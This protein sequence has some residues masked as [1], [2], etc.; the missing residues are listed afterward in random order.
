MLDNAKDH[1]IEIHIS[2]ISCDD[3]QTIKGSDISVSSN[4]LEYCL[5]E[6]PLLSREK[7]KNEQLSHSP[8]ML[9]KWES[10]QKC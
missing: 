2:M 8:L 3:S 7:P 9:S 1:T 6:I 10:L 4:L 5:S